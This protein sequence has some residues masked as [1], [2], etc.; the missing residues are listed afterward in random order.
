MYI[1]IPVR[2][3][4]ENR[5]A[6][7]CTSVGPMS[8][9]NATTMRMGAIR[10]VGTGS[11][12][13][14]TK[15]CNLPPVIGLG[16][17]THRHAACL[18]GRESCSRSARARCPRLVCFPASRAGTLGGSQQVALPCQYNSQSNNEQRTERCGWSCNTKRISWPLAQPTYRSL[19]AVVNV[20][21]YAHAAGKRHVPKACAQRTCVGGLC[22]SLEA[23]SAKSS[24]TLSTSSCS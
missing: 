15:K 4:T 9:V 7:G 22:G 8:K 16:R 17:A 23:R 1:A 12:P 19:P 11:R 14:Y 24:S 18:V 2:F 10:A 5:T 20:I 13:G 3:T 6:G 21:S